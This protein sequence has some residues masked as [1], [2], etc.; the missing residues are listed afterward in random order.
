MQTLIKEFKQVTH[1]WPNGKKVQVTVLAMPK[2]FRSYCNRYSSILTQYFDS[3][4]NAI[5]HKRKQ[6]RLAKSYANR[7]G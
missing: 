4:R 2:L 3:K 5:A 1:T 6:A 7:R